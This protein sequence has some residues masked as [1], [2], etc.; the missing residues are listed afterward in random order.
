MHPRISVNG[1]SSYKWSIEQDLDLA[2]RL[3][4]GT[5]VVPFSKIATDVSTGIAAIKA[6]GIT[7]AMLIGGS[8]AGLLNG[9]ASV[10]SDIDAAAAMGCPA[11]YTISG[12]PPRGAST[13]EA[14]D[15]LVAAL[16]PI[17]AYARAQGI[18][19]ALE[20]T[21]I[22]GRSFSFLHSFADTI[23][24]AKESGVDIVIELQH[25]WYE[26]RLPQLFREN[27]KRIALVQVNDFSIG[28]GLTRNRKVPGDGDIPLE[29][30]IGQLLEAG[31]AGLF[32]IELLGPHI[33]AE[34]YESSIRRSIDWLSER[35]MRWGV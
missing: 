18:R 25:I 11:F 8:E 5:I 27:G 15:A 1:V 14:F 28:E 4:V 35:L 34:G 3:G 30:L 33:E 6:S 16:V 23:D 26:R 20:P 2:K 9:L 17:T 13:D 22:T 7:P 32:D 31:Y 21:S 10:Q 19:F 12:P 24:I 29:W